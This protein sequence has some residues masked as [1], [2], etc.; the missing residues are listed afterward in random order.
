[1]NKL[2]QVLQESREGNNPDVDTS[3]AEEDGIIQ[4]LL[5]NLEKGCLVAIKASSNTS[6]NHRT[7]V[8]ALDRTQKILS[9]T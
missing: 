5:L 2:F 1:L 7:E 6:L 3:E 9:R 4:D 8:E